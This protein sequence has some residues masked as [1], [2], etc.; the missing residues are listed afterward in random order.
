MI[1]SLFPHS[2]QAAKW[3][4]VGLA[5]L[6]LLYLG[7]YVGDSFEPE[8]E[9]APPDTVTRERTITRTD[10]VTQTV[11]DKVIRYDTVRSVDTVRITVPDTSQ[12]MGVIEP[13]PLD[14]S[15]DRATLTYY[16]PDAGRY[17]Q[18]E[19]AIPKD[20]WALFPEVSAR[21]TPLG[22]EAS[23]AIGLRWRDWTVTAGYTTMAGERG[24]TAGVRW[25]PVEWS[26]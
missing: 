2:I 12:I 8:R 4:A 18:N 23:A 11:P 26:W 14:L 3:L 7:D 10:T 17:V 5:G 21:T 24:V 20:R 13:S 15:D 25:R 19:Y 9:P 22:I 6:V 1:S 16:D